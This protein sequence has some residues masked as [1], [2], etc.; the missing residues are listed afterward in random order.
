[1]FVLLESWKVKIGVKDRNSAI[2]ACWHFLA[3]SPSVEVL[4]PS[5]ATTLEM[6]IGI[7]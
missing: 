4:S 2:N 7:S 5:S 3:Q 6:P 1:V